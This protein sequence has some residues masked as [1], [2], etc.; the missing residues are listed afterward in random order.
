LA[1]G[2]QRIVRGEPEQRIELSSDDDLGKLAR[3]FN[4]MVAHLAARD[5]R[6]NSALEDLTRAKANLNLANLELEKRVEERTATLSETVEQLKQEV[7]R[8]SH[9][10]KELQLA[11]RVVENVQEGIVITDSHNRIISVN[12]AFTEITGFTEAEILGLDPGFSKSSRHGPEFYAEMWLQLL[13]DGHWRGEIWNRRKTGELFP[14]L[15]SISLLRD[16][17]GEITNCVGVFSDITQQKQSEERLAQL[18]FYDPLTGLPNRS[19]FRERLERA[20][21]SSERNDGRQFAL[22]FVDL[23]HFKQVNDTLGHAAGDELLTEIGRRMRRAAKRDTDTIARMGGDEF[24]VI[25]SPISADI[26]SSRVAEEIIA[27]VERPLMIKGQEVVIGCSIGIALY[28]EDGRDLEELTRNADV[29]M[30]HAKEKGRNNYQYYRSSLTQ[31]SRER[32]EL[33]QALRH[34][35]DDE[36][37]TLYYQPKWS[38][39]S[40]ELVGFEALIRWR[41]GKGNDLVPPSLFVPLLEESRQIIDVGAWVV[42]SAARQAK[43]WWEQYRRIIPVA[44]NVSARQMADPHFIDLFIVTLERYSLPAGAIE[45]EVTE[46]SIMED[47]KLAADLISGLHELQI[48]VA[49]DDFGTGYS[50][51]GYLKQFKLHTLKVD[52]SFIRDITVDPDDEAIISA[53]ISLADQLGMEV[54]LEGVERFEQL[55]RVMKLIGDNPRIYCQGFLLSQPVSP[56]QAAR[57][58][59]NERLVDPV[60]RL[61]TTDLAPHA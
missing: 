20:C 53:V 31:L 27:Q 46:S 6:I 9:A 43:E 30:Y 28:P 39:M 59:R 3:D 2:T 16:K 40:G 45:V 11:S 55:D 60:A 51:L 23:D 7:L 17:G 10:E 22:F 33:E 37:F 38:V 52:R 1:E 35:L 50:S 58:I 54:V 61:V 8:R 34:A 47:P 14:K 32:M 19:L 36:E 56:A 26:D 15:L 24:T 18:A 49:I 42:E 4:Q 21:A 57:F 41:R 5:L 25:L 13:R 29:A 44:V 12:P 48:P